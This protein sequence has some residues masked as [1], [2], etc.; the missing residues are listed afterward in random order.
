MGLLRRNALFRWIAMW[1]CGLLLTLSPIAF[2]EVVQP[3]MQTLVMG[4]EA[5]YVPFAYHHPLTDGGN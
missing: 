5:D 1:V 4:T 2:P 3:Q